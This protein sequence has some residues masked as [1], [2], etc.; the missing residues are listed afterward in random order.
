MS[1]YEEF[2]KKGHK[3]DPVHDFRELVYRSEERYSELPAF[4]LRD[5][6]VTYREFADDY[7][8][9]VTA[10]LNLGYKDK[11]V[12][13]VGANSYA[14]ILGYL[15]AATVGVVVPIDKELS[16]ADIVNF[17]KE[18]DCTA[19][20]GDENIV[21][22]LE[23]DIVKYVFNTKKGGFTT[24]DDLLKEGRTLYNEGNREVDT[25]P[26]NAEEMSILIFTSGTT[27]NSKGVCLSQKNICANI[28]QTSR[29]V[30]VDKTLHSLSV[31]PLHHTYETTLGH[32]LL[33]SG[34]SC[35]S[36]CD[37]LRHVAKNI[38]EYRPSV[39]IV[40][41]L[42][43]EFILNRINA[44][45]R[46]SLPKR[47]VPSEET[48]LLDMI[49][50]LPAVLRFIVKK[51]VKKSLGGRLRLLIVGAAPIKP[52]I[53]ETFYLLGIAT[54]QGY[55]LTETSPLIAGNNDFYVNPYAVG[56]PIHGVEI[57]IENPNEEGV[58][59]VICKG[60]NVML[61]YY[62]DPEET[63]RVMRNGYFHTGD[64]GRF[65]EDGF[66][67]LAGRCKNVIVAQNGKNI[68]P[69]ELEQRL[70]ESPIISEVLVLGASNSKGGT[71]VKAKIL[72][73]LEKIEETYGK[74]LSKE[75]ISNL[76]LNVVSEINENLPIY[77]KITI[78]E[79]VW[80]AFEK[81][82]TKK[83]KR[84]GTNAE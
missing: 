21:S 81:T 62:N 53:I 74:D 60:D 42:L 65:D 12:A 27:G 10:F 35:I 39:L 72:P 3:V 18:A 33:L 16:S 56:L 37:G 15:A 36:Y 58:G 24:V 75:E 5:R 25:M 1:I 49:K 47:Y 82:T 38:A 76:I 8:V 34:G 71:A 68:Y 54:Y 22:S 63:E 28:Y 67:Y 14:W 45:L 51:K 44:S 64:L 59:E 83:I 29:M 23:C 7:R 9:I 77:K 55:G 2:L 31:L 48:P 40:V 19:V 6:I 79:I 41:P 57:K 61:G 4:Q 66:L 50:G 52:E 70:S 69:E 20:V 26:I 32:L 11:R 43:L 80:E 30:K 78:T 17:I 73:N 13:V 84:F 46:Q